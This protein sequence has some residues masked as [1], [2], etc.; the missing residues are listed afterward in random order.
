MKTRKTTNIF[1]GGTGGQGVLTA[2]EI[3]CWAALYAG[4][5][6]KKSEVHGMAQRGGSVESHVRFAER[7]FSPLIPKGEADFLVCFHRQER[8]RLKGELKKKGLDLTDALD[9]AVRAVQTVSD[10]RM[11]NTYILGCLSRHLPFSMAHWQ[12]AFET[13]FSAPYVPENLKAFRKGRG[14]SS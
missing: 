10:R 14:E 5:H 4:F 12:K 9:D 7:V 3:C 6:V 8:D 13:V 1:F 11:V 2:S